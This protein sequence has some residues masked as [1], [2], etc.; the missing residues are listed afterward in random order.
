LI[1]FA[2]EMSGLGAYAR[3]WEPFFDGYGRAPDFE[4]FRLRLLGAAGREFLDSWAGTREQIL[5]HILNAQSW[6]DLFLKQ[7]G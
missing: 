7:I 2:I 3:W 4:L 1:K 5:T 6:E